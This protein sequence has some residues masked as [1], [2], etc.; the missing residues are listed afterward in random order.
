[1]LFYTIFRQKDMVDIMQSP[2]VVVSVADPGESTLTISDVCYTDRGMYVCVVKNRLGRVKTR[3]N[4]HVGDGKSYDKISIIKEY[5][6]CLN[7]LYDIN[8]FGAVYAH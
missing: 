4:L 5:I 6:K 7:S 3:C 2:R 1:M 8:W